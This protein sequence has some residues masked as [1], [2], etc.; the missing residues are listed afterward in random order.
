M[1]EVSQ[2]VA[3]A[4]NRSGNIRA[5]YSQECINWFAVESYNQGI[6]LLF[7]GEVTNAERMLATA[8][9][10]LP[11]CGREVEC[12]AAEMRLAYHRAVERKNDLSASL[13]IG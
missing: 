9:N 4:S 5:L 3:L 6:N 11:S 13:S 8:L 2:E 1:E 12:H 10:F 7:L